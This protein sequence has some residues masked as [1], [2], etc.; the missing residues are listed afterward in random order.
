MTVSHTENRYKHMVKKKKVR[1]DK[2]RN[3]DKLAA[4]LA[5]NPLA[6]TREA[7]EMA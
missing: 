5:K 7:A 3:V 6:S 2:K 1:V 4:V